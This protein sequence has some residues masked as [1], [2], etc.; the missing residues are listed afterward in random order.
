MLYV[1]S[2]K[3]IE[4]P[5]SVTNASVGGTVD[6]KCIAEGTASPPNWNINGEDYRVTE[7]PLNHEYHSEGYLEITPITLSMNNSIYYCYYTPY[8][9]GDFIR[10][11]SEHAY[12]LISLSGILLYDIESTINMFCMLYL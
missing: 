11:E 4:G 12:L 1:A 10:I 2:L 6:Y 5:Q 8:V 9:D 7:L 3:I